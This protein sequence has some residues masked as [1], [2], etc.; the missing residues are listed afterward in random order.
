[1]RYFLLVY[2]RRRAKIMQ[3][4][5]YPEG[6]R[7]RALDDARRL[8]L[9]SIFD[10]AIEVVILGGKSFDDLKKTHSRYFKKAEEIISA[11]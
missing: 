1:M 11:A 8:Q 3:Q 7:E 6:Q 10:P 5:E 2:D 4:R 9:Q